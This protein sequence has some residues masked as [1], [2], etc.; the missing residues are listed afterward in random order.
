[1]TVNE[2]LSRLGTK[3]NKAEISRRAGLAPTAYSAY[4]L[5][6]GTIP[7]A[8]IA[9]RLARS[10]GVSVEWL[11]DDRQEW[12]PVWVNY[13]DATETATSAA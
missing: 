1:M 10:I 9:L 7:R 11:I 5:S 8:D 13:P 4:A 6:K 3:L 2:K 12:P